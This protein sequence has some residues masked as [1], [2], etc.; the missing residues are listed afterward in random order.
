M[1]DILAYTKL[2]D[3]YKNAIRSAHKKRDR[4]NMARL[5]NKANGGYRDVKR[6]D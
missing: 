2:I 6:A 1:E 3:R 5:K 4:K